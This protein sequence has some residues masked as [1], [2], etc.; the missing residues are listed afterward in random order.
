M[1]FQIKQNQWPM[2]LK[3]LITEKTVYKAEIKDTYQKSEIDVPLLFV[4]VTT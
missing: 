1:C 2:K 3:L 4:P